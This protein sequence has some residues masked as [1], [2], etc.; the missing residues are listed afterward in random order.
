MLWVSAGLPPV[1][2][3]LLTRE[4]SALIALAHVVNQRFVAPVWMQWPGRSVVRMTGGLPPSPVRP[5]WR[6]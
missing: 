5:R 6:S 2:H 3:L 1:V 4:C